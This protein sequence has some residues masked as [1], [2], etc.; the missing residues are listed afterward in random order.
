MYEK[1]GDVK[2]KNTD[3]NPKNMNAEENT[4][5]DEKDF[6]FKE[7]IFNIF[8][9][10]KIYKI[11]Q[12]SHFIVNEQRKVNLEYSPTKKP[13]SKKK[14]NKF[15]DLISLLAR[16]S[17]IIHYLIQ[18]NKLKDAKNLL[19]L[20]IKENIKHID[21][22]TFKLF[23]IYNKLQQ[24]YEIISVYPK[25]IKDLFQVYSILIKYCTL[26]NFSSYRSLF[27]VRYL[28]LHSLNYKVFKRK[29]E[30]RGFG[31]EIRNELKYLFSICLHY[32]SLFTVKTYYPLKIPISLSGL[33]L[34]VYRNLDE[35][36]AT[37]KEKSLI[38][39]TLYNQ[40][41]FFYLNNQNDMALKNLRMIKQK[42]IFFNN[43]EKEK[44][45]F[46]HNFIK[47]FNNNLKSNEVNIDKKKSFYKNLFNN[48]KETHNNKKQKDFSFGSALDLDQIFLNETNRKKSIK[49]DDIIY[50]LN[51][52]KRRLPIRK[53]NSL[54][55]G[56][57][58]KNELEK[59][60]QIKLDIPNYIKEPIFFKIELFMTEI[61]FDRKNYY[62]SYEHIKNC[63][64]IIIIS[65]KLE[66]QNNNF[67]NQKRLNVI[68]NYLEEI[69]KKNRDKILSSKIKSLQNLNLTLNPEELDKLEEVNNKK[70][71]IINTNYKI[72]I[73]N[74][75]EKLF[76]FLN[77]LSVYQIKI[78]NDTQPNLDSRNDM[79]IFFSNQL[80]DTLTQKQRNALEKLNIMS[81]NRSALL[82]NPNKSIL[83]YNLKFAKENNNQSTS[84]KEKTFRI[85]FDGSLMNN[86]NFTFINEENKSSEQN[87]FEFII[88]GKE[89]KSLRRILLSS[90]KN[91]K[92]KTYLMNNIYYINKILVNSNNKQIE[93]MI[94]YPKIIVE[95][96]K[97]FKKRYK[98]DENYNSIKKEI[99]R[100]LKENPKFKFLFKDKKSI[101]KEKK[102]DNTTDKKSVN[103][104]ESVT[105][106]YDIDNSSLDEQNMS[107]K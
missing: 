5:Q 42:L 17:I 63:L 55:N 36:I 84:R 82:Q 77:S 41:I 1:N 75:I 32:A 93:D 21:Y 43:K 44:K 46:Y 28:S 73:K 103:S 35:N 67:E 96:I 62:M 105:D 98:C 80:K 70:K 34:K 72:N 71:E 102:I 56:E 74:E 64:L 20:M 90:I 54:M 78:F 52:N 79:P 87:T 2:L 106:S 95:P 6:D 19:H 26:F 91:N 16:Y 81:V 99:I 47:L 49:L 51:L 92:L 61:E 23:K 29:F 15:Q 83:P 100:K 22:Q 38:I 89:L 65:K 86:N 97:L 88:A 101:S 45:N 8:N 40:S 39:N 66:N 7:I 85:N 3:S 27:L 24:K 76:L 9:Q 30:M 107:E 12:L 33:I 13:S 94:K 59:Y 68:S 4:F 14:N 60:D 18:K 25:P 58:I 104:S 11:E 53:S 10:D 31:E 37:K 48:P 57:F 50:K 69:K